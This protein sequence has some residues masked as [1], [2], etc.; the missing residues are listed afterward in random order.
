M[1]L[2]E[3]HTAD[4]D[5]ADG[6]PP[7]RTIYPDA[8]LDL[9][10]PAVASPGTAAQLGRRNGRAMRASYDAEILRAVRVSE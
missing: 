1:L 8:H 3:G 2:P 10:T 4:A 6:P 5:D 9:P 7:A